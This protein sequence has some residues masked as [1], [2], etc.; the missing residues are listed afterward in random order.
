[1]NTSFYNA[2][3]ALQAYQQG[4]GVISNN[5]ANV[6][7]VAYK[8]D[9][10]SFEDCIYT[11][12]HVHIRPEDLLQ[13]HGVKLSQVGKT[14]NQGSFSMTN[15][16][17]DFAISDEDYF[18]QFEKPDGTRV[19]SKAGNFSLSVEDEGV[20]LVNGEGYYVLD[21]EGERIPLEE[22]SDGTLD[23]DKLV[24]TIGLFKFNNKYELTKDGG[25][26]YMAT[27]KSGLAEPAELAKR[28]QILKQGSLEDSAT[29]L[30]DEMVDLIIYQR[31][32]QANST[33]IQT[34]DEIEDIV[35]HLRR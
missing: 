3:T 1:M 13:G 14:F 2:Y 8:T 17:T 34:A 22:A 9:K 35:N 20:F 4:L 26:N 31:A 33:M 27:E 5:I 19:F 29:D 30:A 11:E 24:D 18:F 7:T 12:M 32:F 23:T 16:A 15:N 21:A 25:N 28:R 6:N 10:S